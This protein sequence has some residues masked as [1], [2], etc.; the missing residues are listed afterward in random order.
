MKADSSEQF[1][2][3]R[4]TAM[5][6]AILFG[7]L[8]IGMLLQSSDQSE[9]RRKCE[10]TVASVLENINRVFDQTQILHAEQLRAKTTLRTNLVNDLANQVLAGAVHALNQEEKIRALKQ[11]DRSQASISSLFDALVFGAAEPEQEATA[12]MVLER[13]RAALE[14][15]IPEGVSIKITDVN[16]TELLR[17]GTSVQN[18]STSFS[19]NVRQDA[20]WAGAPFPVLVQ[21][22]A[23]ELSVSKEP[24]FDDYVAALFDDEYLR[25]IQNQHILITIFDATG[26]PKA[27]LP[28]K[29]APFQPSDGELGMWNDAEPF[30]DVPRVRYAQKLSSMDSRVPVAVVRVLLEEP[31]T[32]RWMMQRLKDNPAFAA[33]SLCGIA[34]VVTMISM[35]RNHGETRE[36]GFGR[37]E[38]FSLQ[39]KVEKHVPVVIEQKSVASPVHE[40]GQAAPQQSEEDD[41]T[42]HMAPVHMV[43]PVKIS[44]PDPDRASNLLEL[45]K[46]FHSRGTRGMRLGDAV[47]SEL[48]RELLRRVGSTDAGQADLTDGRNLSDSYDADRIG[49]RDV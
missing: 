32:A 16:G 14:A 17:Y 49:D 41:E 7:L 48:L 19:A 11:S 29:Q 47:R 39:R 12:A 8:A 2:Q 20:R 6:A 35:R 9:T 40:V 3:W 31:R 26:K 27:T 5:L 33:V 36:A 45:R 25:V 28:V 34:A 15:M 1:Q 23:P 37:K 13:E 46:R 21:V 18:K 44:R 30:A 4:M 10:E 24:S 38:S 43:S 42:V 22:Q